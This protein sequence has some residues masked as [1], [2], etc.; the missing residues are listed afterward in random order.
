MTTWYEAD[1]VKPPH[2]KL[3]HVRVA[4]TYNERA[5][6]W[7]CFNG[8]QF[9]S[10]VGGRV[11]EWC[12]PP[13]REEIAEQYE[14]RDAKLVDAEAARD[15]AELR[16]AAAE[17]EVARLMA[18]V[19]ALEEMTRWRQL[20]KTPDETGWVLIL[21]S[22]GLCD[23]HMYDGYWPAEAMGWQPLPSRR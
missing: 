6:V 15:V 2:E 17:D 10:P 4:A 20:D 22:T 14:W 18:Q 23:R 19:A 16:A 5:G 8:G 9:T 13:T 7:R 11:L 1:E 3:V 21:W 12:Y